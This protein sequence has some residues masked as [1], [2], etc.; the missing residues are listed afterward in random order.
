MTYLSHLAEYS[1][2]YTTTSSADSATST[3]AILIGLSIELFVFAV[4]YAVT[5]LLL[6]R[7]FKKAGVKP[8]IA[9]VPFYSRWKML[10][11]GGQQG[12]WAVLTI[13]PIVNIVSAVFTY[14]ALYHIGKKLEKSGA[15][16]LWG[17]FL[18]IVWYIWLAVDE[19][20][21]DDKASTA[22]S[23]AK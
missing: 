6:S 8:W 5:A 18:P 16:V 15:F 9:W 12:F 3:V 1:S 19:S 23:L 21:W 22:P 20:K 10:E 14:I 7:I 11:I 4:V 13:I 2:Y 17:I